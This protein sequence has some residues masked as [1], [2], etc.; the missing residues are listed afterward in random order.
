MYRKCA[1]Q[2]VHYY[3]LLSVCFVCNSI[4]ENGNSNEQCRCCRV[5]SLDLV[6]PVI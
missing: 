2:M 1:L 4:Y 6:I 5:M 3:Y